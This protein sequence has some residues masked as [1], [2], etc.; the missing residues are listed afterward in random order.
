MAID[1]DEVDVSHFGY[2]ITRASVT[3]GNRLRAVV[4]VE[5]K[6]INVRVG[7]SFD[8]VN[9][10]SLCEYQFIGRTW[11]GRCANS[12]VDDAIHIFEFITD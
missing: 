5:C 11:K 9:V 12:L 6:A 2:G 8:P 1:T 4:L 7:S 3:A 10:L